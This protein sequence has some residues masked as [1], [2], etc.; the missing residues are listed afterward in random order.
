MKQFFTFLLIVLICISCK[1]N[2]PSSEII[3]ESQDNPVRAVEDES[4]TLQEIVKI[5]IPE[6]V[7]DIITYYAVRV[8]ANKEGGV[9]A[10]QIEGNFTGSG[11]REIIAFYEYSEI[12]YEYLA[13]T[14]VFC[15]VCDSSGDEIE[16][17]YEIKYGTLE[18][19]E[20]NE[21]KIGLSDALGRK[22]VWRGQTICRIGDFNGNGREEPYL[23][24]QTGM[25]NSLCFFE[26]Y[27]TEFLEIINLGVADAF[28]TS[29]DQ[30]KRI[31]NI[32]IE[33]N[34]EYLII[35]N[36][37]YFWDIVTLRYEILITTTKTK[38]YRW[39]WNTQE[40]EEIEES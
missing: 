4:E 26:F 32:Q 34:S 10:L 38:K 20:K 1:K 19:N 15:F 28:I 23:Y 29:V 14:N 39:N 6:A 22:I 9:L 36:N 21:A 13:I 40:Y 37:S 11:N 30:E 18:F 35:K 25:N 12:A 3:I 31:I 33:Y 17:V 2:N 16:S 24:Y 5:P 7:Q 8:T 27:E